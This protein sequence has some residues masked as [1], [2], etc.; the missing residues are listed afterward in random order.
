MEY[1]MQDKKR[2]TVRHLVIGSEKPKICVP[3]VG[4]TEVEICTQVKQVLAE[5]PDLLEWRIDF[6]EQVHD[7]ETLL[8]VAGMIRELVSDMPLLVTFR[9]EA[10]GGEQSV[11][12]EEYIDLYTALAMSGVCDMLDVELFAAKRMGVDNADE[13]T[14]ELIA[15]LHANGCAVI[16]SSHDFEQTPSKEELIMRMCHMQSLGADIAKVAM[17]PQSQSDVDVLM[18]ATKEMYDHY[19]VIPIVTMS[20]GELGA[21]SRL[22][23]ELTGSAITFGCCGAASAPGQIEVPKLRKGLGM[24]HTLE[25][26]KRKE[27]KIFLI[28]FMGSGKSSVSAYLQKQYGLEEVDTDAFIVEKEGRSITDIFEQNGE[29]YFRQLETQV[30]QEL[31]A[32]KGILVSCGGGMAVKPENVALMKQ[33]GIVVLLTAKPETILER[34]KDDDSRP[35][36]RGNKNTA[37]IEQLI[38]KRKNSYYTAAD[39]VVP[40]DALSVS[41][42]GDRIMNEVRGIIL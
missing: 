13:A 4:K 16:M 32:R 36:L 40:T 8:K 26:Q 38:N 7:R 2:L 30:L 34:V 22:N 18:A 41:E 17:M 1:M 29:D 33:Q 23:G 24:I 3:I 31:A 9:T 37:F 6:F 25:M 5:K 11:S 35:I 10:E 12:W 14:G 15:S 39:I 27:G 19:A 42:V 21:I 28:G 20:M